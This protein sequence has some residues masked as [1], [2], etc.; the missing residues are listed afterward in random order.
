MQF[1]FAPLEGI[2]G[3]IFRNAHHAFYDGIDKYYAPFL[4]PA[5]NCVMNPKERRDVLV[6]N[7]KGIPLVPQ[8]LANNAGYFTEAE[9][10]LRAYGYKE[11]NLN[12]GCP[13]RTVVTKKKGAGFL[14]YPDELD[15]FLEQIF[16]HAEGG[17][18]V[19]TRI[20]MDEEEEFYDLLAIYN[21]YPIKELIIHP[22]TQK[23]YYKN[24]P[25]MHM[26]AYAME[27]SANPVCY[28]GD[29]LTVSDYENLIKEFEGLHAVMIG[30]GML[31]NPALI[32]Q[33]TKNTPAD[34]EVL[35][36]FHDKLY[37]DY[38]Q[39]MSGEKNVLYKMKEVWLYLLGSFACGEA[40]R[41][42]MK[43]VQRLRDYENLVNKLFAEG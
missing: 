20:G 10:A 5:Q 22:R 2:T 40:Y 9:K 39:F 13:S 41:K 27:H 6:E 19:K 38:M 30:R 35:R 36:G 28:N 3:Y 43:K 4:S 32:T 15:R 7:N 8:I 21:K 33:I 11:V 25:H 23:D 31:T 18:S 34:K 37:Q 16:S 1:Y 29:I 14:A 24:A 12:L 42:D 17:I 26:V